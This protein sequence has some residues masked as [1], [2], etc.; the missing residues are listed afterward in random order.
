MALEPENFLRPFF[1]GEFDHAVGEILEDAEIP[2]LVSL[3]QV[4]PGYMTT[5][6]E[7]VAF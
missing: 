4:A 3:R 1:T 7:M 5:D 6:T 2:V